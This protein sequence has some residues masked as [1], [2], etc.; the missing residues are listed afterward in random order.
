MCTVPALG[1]QRDRNRSRLAADNSKKRAAD[2]PKRRNAESYAANV[3]EFPKLNMMTGTEN[4][5][6]AAL[7]AGMGAILVSANIFT[8]QVAAVFQAHRAAQDTAD[9]FA[10]LRD[11]N[12]LL[13]PGGAS[14]IKF[15]FSGLGIRETYV[16]P[17][18]VDLTDQQKSQLRDRFAQLKQI[19]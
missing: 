5:L 19:V 2:D 12:Q 8:K 4:N 16:R 18:Q 14:G 6:P 1:P 13:R 17:P 11:A 15:A 3:K 7:A 10:K 9:A